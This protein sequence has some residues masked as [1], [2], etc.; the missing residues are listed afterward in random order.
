MEIVKK[1]FKNQQWFNLNFNLWIQILWFYITN[2]DQWSFDSQIKI[3]PEFV[4]D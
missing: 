3:E 1:K 4:L 2:I